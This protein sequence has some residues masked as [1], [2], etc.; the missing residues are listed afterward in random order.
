MKYGWI[1]KYGRQPEVPRFFSAAE[2]ADV[3]Q[4]YRVHTDAP[5]TPLR[6]LP[7]LANALGVREL[8][9]KD[10]SRRFGLPAFK[11]VGARYAIAK[12]LESSRERVTD[13]AC[14]TAGN[15]GR[16]VA[17]LARSH[18]L[19]AHVYV[20]AGT[21]SERVSALQAEGADIVVSDVDY[22]ATVARMARDAEARGWTIVSDTAWDGYEQIPRWIMAG[23]TRILDEA[24]DEWGLTPPDVVIV[25]TGVG[26]LT[27]AV[28][29]WLETLAP[30][31]RPRLVSAEPEGSACLLASLAAGRRVTLPA[32]APTAMVGLRCAD[33][34]TLA[35]EA[36]KDRGDA[37]IAVPED[38][39][40]E[41]QE[42]LAT[43][44]GGDPSIQSG[45]SGSCGVAALFMMMRDSDLAP[46]RNALRLPESRVLCI[47]T[48]SS[49]A[50]S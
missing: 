34:S 41:A 21:S 3:R 32:C 31:T 42:R 4:F 48:E 38:V 33:V 20:P 5:A 47:V 45:A 22:D 27:G 29:G 49:S 9:I 36:L 13:L 15:H 37:A 1:K 50:S 40:Q 25:Q 8:L 7:A 16:A 14:A 28:A 46:I 30:E 24:A 23:Y 43:P 11:I 12:L 44:A 26:S 35:W 19:G 39:N 6:R 2:L 17:H 18:G 10:E